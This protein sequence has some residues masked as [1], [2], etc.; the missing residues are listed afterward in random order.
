MRT[1]VAAIYIAFTLPMSAFAQSGDLSDTQGAIRSQAEVMA[2]AFEDANYEL[3][4]NYTYPPIIVA[5]GGREVLQ[6]MIAQMM[7][8]IAKQGYIVD[9]V[10]IGDPGQ[11]YAAGDEWHAIIPERIYMT[12]P[13]GKLFSETPLLAISQDKGARWYYL[14]TNQLTPELKESFFPQFNEDLKIPAPKQTLTNN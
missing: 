3:L 14:D 2:Q 7:E 1:F 10:R 8:D 13:E 5:A 9:S 4:L 11:I 6:E 12:T